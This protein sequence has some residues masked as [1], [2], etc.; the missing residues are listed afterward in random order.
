MIHTT[1]YRQKD[2]GWQII[3][4]WKDTSGRWRQKSKQ[5]F[6][7]KSD[8]KEYEVQLLQQIK[9]QP[10]PVDQSMAD[11]TLLD[12]TE[13]FLKARHSLAPGSKLAYTTAVNSLKELAKK[14]VRSITFM[15]LQKAV[16]DWNI[17]PWTQKMYKA[18]L[19][20]IF[21]AAVKPYGIISVNPM[22]DIEIEKYRQER[23]TK[24]VTEEHFRQLLD[25]CTDRE[26]YIAF[27]LAWY[28]GMRRAEYLALTWED[29]DMSSATVTV[30]K[31]ISGP[32]PKS[33]NGYRTIPIP[34]TLISELK[35]YKIALPL[36]LDKKLFASPQSLHKRMWKLMHNLIGS[37]PH[38]LRHTY[39][40][41]LIAE[42]VDVQTAAA[43][44]GDHVQTVINTYIHYTDDMRAAAAKDIEKIFAKNF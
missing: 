13:E 40:T 29:I 36:R 16:R 5:G 38:H 9:K 1:T 39:G 19:D 43:L 2:N 23:K 3:V 15:D 42:G 27:L 4:S 24:T 17:K 25:A 37:T 12:F 30:N 44:M 21:R 26:M 31:Q 20:I 33:N 10:R 8:A 41:R 14:P 7:K 22:E 35:K 11:I 32:Y 6:A 34:A 18:K 28:T